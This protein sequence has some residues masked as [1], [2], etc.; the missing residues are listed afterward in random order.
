MYPVNTFPIHVF[1]ITVLTLTALVASKFVFLLQVCEQISVISSTLFLHKHI[2]VKSCN[3]SLIQMRLC[4][5]MCH[6]GYIMLAH[7]LFTG[8]KYSTDP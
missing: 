3:E 6:Q 8:L 4:M 5:Y 7:P 2:I 1:I